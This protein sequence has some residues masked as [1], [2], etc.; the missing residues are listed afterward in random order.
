MHEAAAES[1]EQFAAVNDVAAATTKKLEKQAALAGYFAKLDTSDLRR[2]T[3]FAGGKA[4]SSTDER[5]LGVSGATM[6]EVAT[7]LLGV[8]SD[9]Y[10]AATV[11]EGEVGEALAK[12][13]PEKKPAGDPLTL[14][15]VADAFDALASTGNF[16]EKRDAV[17]GLLAR[18]RTP[19]EAAYVGKVIFG[20]LRTGAREGVLL[21]AVAEAFGREFD[22]V[23][24]AQLL[25]GDL[26][27]VAV[28]AK[29]DRLAEATFQLFHPIQFMLASPLETP[30][31]AAARLEGSELLSK[32]IAEDKLDGVR[33]QVH[34]SGDRLAIYTR[35]LDRS[36]ES[37]PD[38][39][40]ELLRVPGDWLLDGE[41]VP[42]RG[43]RVLPFVNMQKRLGRKTLT[44]KLLRDHPLTFVAFDCLFR[45]GVN[46][47]DAPLIDRRAVLQDLAE[48]ASAPG[49]TAEGRGPFR[50]GRAV[51]VTDEPAI[52]AAFDAARAARNEGLILKDPQSVYAPGR[53]GLAWFKLKTHLPTLD[54][55]V[56]AAEHGHGKRRN[57]LSDYTFAVWDTD[58][59]HED[60]KLV[61]IGKAYS[62]VTDAEIEELTQTFLELQ[63]GN[64]GRVYT[65]KPTIVFEIAFDQIQRSARHAGGYALRFPRIKRI[66][67]DK[68]PEDADTL[69]RVGELYD[70]PDNFGRVE[71]KADDEPTLFG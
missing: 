3:R 25:V 34:K 32:F 54:C 50:V 18:C 6:R 57:H 62:G 30:A 28:L 24:R 51:E 48:K 40:E 10:Q 38:V 27:E 15:A 65:V 16:A 52:T 35:T 47:M 5:V 13:W 19:R 55:V 67:R 60:A 26:D 23:R 37:Y 33:A 12:L 20:D 70:S 17:R 53:R 63:T 45:D 39:V 1:W 22:A 2:A 9:I 7:T 8:P 66:R 44:P 68:R 4:F 14:H 64:Y 36:D 69:A 29:E 58:P 49:L 59:S 46:L 43:G 11:A 41:I 31:D 71:E 21:A 61:N 42:F 56:T